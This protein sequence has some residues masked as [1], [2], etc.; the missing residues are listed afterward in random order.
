VYDIAIP[1]E[2]APG[3]Y[4]VLLIVYHADTGAEVGRIDGGAVTLQ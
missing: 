1:R 2:L 4:G 3:A